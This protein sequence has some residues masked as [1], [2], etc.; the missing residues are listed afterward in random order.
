MYRLGGNGQG[1]NENMGAGFVPK[2]Q[3]ATSDLKQA[4]L[5]LAKDLQS[6]PDAQAEFS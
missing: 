4:R 3:A 1:T 5:S 2:T 6:N